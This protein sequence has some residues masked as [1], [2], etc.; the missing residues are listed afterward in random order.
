M[1]LR[2]VSDLPDPGGDMLWLL[3]G[4]AAHR[5]E[6]PVAAIHHGAVVEAPAFPLQSVWVSAVDESCDAVADGFRFAW[7]IHAEQLIHRDAAIRLNIQNC[8]VDLEERI[9]LDPYQTHESGIDSLDALLT[10]RGWATVFVERDGEVLEVVRVEALQIDQ[11]D[12]IGGGRYDWRAP[13]T[14]AVEW[15]LVEELEANLMPLA[16]LRAP[17]PDH[18]SLMNAVVQTDVWRY[19][20]SPAPEPPVALDEA[21]L[22][23]QEPLED[24]RGQGAGPVSLSR[25]AGD[26]EG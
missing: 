26:P 9:R 18:T 17:R 8:G 6:L 4:C 23:Q 3:L 7:T 2:S 21:P 16:V 5:V 14:A 24:E 22:A 19:A 13:L 11:Q 1:L 12:W 25:S 20:P 10:G 15:A